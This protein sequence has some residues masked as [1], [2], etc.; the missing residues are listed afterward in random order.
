MLLMLS[1]SNVSFTTNTVRQCS[2]INAAPCRR[3]S[4][5][6]VAIRG[7]PRARSLIVSLPDRGFWRLS[8]VAVL[9]D[10][11]CW[12][13]AWCPH[14]S[15]CWS[16]YVVREWEVSCPSQQGG[17]SASL[18][19]RTFVAMRSFIGLLYLLRLQC[20]CDTD[21]RIWLSRSGN[22]P[23]LGI[24]AALPEARSG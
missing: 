22:C 14:L 13:L 24:A 5:P 17:N 20:V 9:L 23:S 10:S 15:V 19:M 21:H 12:A 18:K 16:I 4:T 8:V 7:H 3:L 6:V 2:R 1:T 11:R